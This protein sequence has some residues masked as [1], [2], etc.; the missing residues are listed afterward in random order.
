VGIRITK[1]RIEPDAVTEL[2]KTLD[3]IVGHEIVFSLGPEEADPS[4][5]L[6]DIRFTI[7][8][9][10]IDKHRIG[11]FSKDHLPSLITLKL[12]QI[13][14]FYP[15]G[16]YSRIVVS[17]DKGGE[18]ELRFKVNYAANQNRAMQRATAVE[19]VEAP[20]T[21]KPIIKIRGRKHGVGTPKRS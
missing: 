15:T 2:C 5:R 4:I 21:L 20:A 1:I 9:Y 10:R 19:V 8:E 16:R 6:S 18:Q 17:D 12:G 11:L 14:K 3:S 13:K 7:S